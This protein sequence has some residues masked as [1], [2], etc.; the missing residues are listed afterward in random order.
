M[1]KNK[2]IVEVEIVDKNNV[3]KI[4]K[5]ENIGLVVYGIFSVIVHIIISNNF[6][7]IEGLNTVVSW[8]LVLAGVS[9]FSV[10]ISKKVDNGAIGFFGSFLV[11]RTNNSSTIFQYKDIK[12]YR[13]R[14]QLMDGEVP[15]KY[16]LELD[17]QG[18]CYEYE[19]DISYKCDVA[20]LEK[21]IN[22]AMQRPSI[23]ASA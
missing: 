13:I 6:D 18:N 17:S 16:F 9:I 3:A 15:D 19:I 7:D 2:P 12:S 1:K 5:R 4:K 22:D 14:E 11:V 10:V 20:P 23:V 8:M 21:R